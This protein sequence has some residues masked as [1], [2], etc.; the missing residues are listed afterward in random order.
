MSYKVV[1][2]SNKVDLC[3]QV[4]VPTKPDAVRLARDWASSL[5]QMGFVVRPK[6]TVGSWEGHRPLP[7]GRVD[8]AIIMVL[9]E[10]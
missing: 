3:R 2:T 6:A 9:R 1:L 7:G 8:A 5:R 10:Y 4:V